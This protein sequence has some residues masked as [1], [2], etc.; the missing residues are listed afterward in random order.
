MEIN[1]LIPLHHFCEH[2]NIENSFVFA[3]NEHD[4]VKIYIV[5]GKTFLHHD[6]IESLE[7]IIRLYHDLAINFEGIDVILQLLCR[8]E[9]LQQEL[10]F[11]KQ[12]LKEFELE[13][14]Y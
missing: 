13:V 2:H 1:K 6:S 11:T 9:E 8:I 7:K 10:N 3:L 12:K 5:E 14:M 4:L